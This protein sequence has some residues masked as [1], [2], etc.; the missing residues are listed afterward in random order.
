LLALLE[1]DESWSRF[2]CD[3]AALPPF[4]PF[5]NGVSKRQNC[6]VVDSSTTFDR[7]APNKRAK[8]AAKP[9]VNGGKTVR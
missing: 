5:L 4:S 3:A 6:Q 9:A 1:Q 8:T 7:S 2:R